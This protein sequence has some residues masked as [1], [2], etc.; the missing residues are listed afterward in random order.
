MEHRWFDDEMIWKQEKDGE[1][2]P[3]NPIRP[4]WAQGLASIPPVVFVEVWSQA[5][6]LNDVQKVF[7]WIATDE[8]IKQRDEISTWLEDNGFRPL[9]SLA[10]R[11]EC[12]L[13]ER[14][15]EGLLAKGCIQRAIS[16]E[17]M[18][19]EEEVEEEPEAKSTPVEQDS[20]Y[21]EVYNPHQ[22]IQ[23]SEGGGMRFRVRH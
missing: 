4:E 8:I 9:A 17:E 18:E 15:L 5:D 2:I 20:S 23:I 14:Q 11:S 13:S 12:M 6:A 10:P 7:F 1:W 3:S 16:E 21:E 22:H 19:E